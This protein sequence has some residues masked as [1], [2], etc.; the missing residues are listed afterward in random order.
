MSITLYP[1]K[2][3]FVCSCLKGHLY[4][5]FEI[6]RKETKFEPYCWYCKGEGKCIKIMEETLK[7]STNWNN[8][9]NCN[10]FVTLRLRNDNKYYTGAKVNIW[11]GNTYK[12]KATIVGVSFYTLDKINEFV[13]RLDTG[14]SAEECRKII[15]EMYKNKPNIDWFTQ[16]LAFCLI[17]YDERAKQ[18]DLFTEQTQE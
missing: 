10:S 15:M 1:G 12:G 11:L 16:Q 5:P 14:Y 6:F 9:L 18:P 4:E 13:A 2:Y 17:S 8:K 3:R 7:F